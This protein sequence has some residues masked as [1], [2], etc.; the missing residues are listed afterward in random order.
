MTEH[1]ELSEAENSYW[2]CLNEVIAG[3]GLSL[4]DSKL[5]M[6]QKNLIF[7]D[8]AARIV[9]EPTFYEGKQEGSLVISVRDE[10]YLP[11]IK[12]A[13][14]YLRLCGIPAVLEE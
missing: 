13:C 12:E 10:K 6:K 7:S 8:L 4:V 1:K 2:F 14:H 11:Q 9:T 3:R 5:I